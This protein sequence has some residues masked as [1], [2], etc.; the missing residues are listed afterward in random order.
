M[1]DNRL[2]QAN[3]PPKTKNNI[4]KEIFLL[5]IW[6]GHWQASIWAV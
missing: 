5:T 2:T 6:V 4:T 1:K 3:L